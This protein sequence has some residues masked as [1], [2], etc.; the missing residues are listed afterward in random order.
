MTIPKLTG[1]KLTGP[2][3]TGFALALMSAPLLATPVAQD[4]D[5]TITVTG[6]RFSPS[7][8]RKRSNDFVN[9]TTALSEDQYS[10]RTNPIC[11]RVMGIDPSY[12]KI[13][14]ARVRSVAEVAGV[15]QA[16]G[17]CNGNLFILFTFDANS[18][19]TTLHK[20]KPLLFLDVPIRSRKSLLSGAQPIRWW[21]INESRNSENSVI[22][23]ST[24]PDGVVVRES[25]VQSSSLIDSKL[26]VTLQGSVVVIDVNKSMGYPLGAV[27]DYAAMVSMAQVRNDT[28]FAGLPSIL[29]LFSRGPDAAQS[30]AGL[31]RFDKAYLSSL[32]SVAIDR[33]RLVQKSQI[34]GR[35]A[36]QLGTSER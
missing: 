28:D 24:R 22:E 20:A 27:A 32:N 31:T 30:Q 14:E 6:E 4:S 1:P 18:L 7:E 10:R 5:R 2:K 23:E 8:A 29:S 13:V 16:Q 9:V 19:M 15:P 26:T 17:E 21:H 12:A 35:M 25:R 34:V 36:A 3:L 11:P 33:G